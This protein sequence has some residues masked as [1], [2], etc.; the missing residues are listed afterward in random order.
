MCVRG[1]GP[2]EPRPKRPTGEVEE[3]REKNVYLDYAATETL[4]PPA[5]IPQ[6]RAPCGVVCSF[7]PPAGVKLPIQRARLLRR[8]TFFFFFLIYSPLTTTKATLSICKPASDLFF[9]ADQIGSLVCM[10]SDPKAVE[11]HTC[12]VMCNNSRAP[13]IWNI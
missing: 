12:F 6:E 1:S 5:V 11:V 9:S 7:V 3:E 8:E 10:Q 13:M 2:L 4:D